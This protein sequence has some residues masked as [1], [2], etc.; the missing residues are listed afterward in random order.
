MPFAGS[1]TL[2]GGRIPSRAEG[3]RMLDDAERRT[4][5]E[6]ERQLLSQDPGL[7]AR[8]RRRVGWYRWWPAL[9]LGVGVALAV[10]LVLLGLLGQAVLTVLITAIPLATRRWRHRISRDAVSNDATPQDRP[11]Y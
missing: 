9:S 11:P 3:D 2:A 6:M 4:L 8:G 10:G 5:A 1:T 7:D